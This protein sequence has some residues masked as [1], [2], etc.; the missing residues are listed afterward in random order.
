M[1][2]RTKLILSYILI[3]IVVIFF[4]LFFINIY[5]GKQFSEIIIKGMGEGYLVL[6]TPKGRLFLHAMKNALIWSGI[7]TIL[8]GTLLALFLS[9]I[10]SSPLKEMEN[11]AKRIS[12]GDYT[13]RI[14]VNQEDELGHLEKTL[15]KM[16]ENL[17]EIENMRKSLVQN[18]SHDLRT[19][20]TSLKGYIEI[21]TDPEFTK[22]E[23]Q[24]AIKVI[25]LEIERMESMLEELS[26]L[27]AIDSRRYELK[28][29][30]I[31]LKDAIN[32]AVELMEINAKSKNLAIE[33]FLEDSVYIIGDKKRI[34]EIMI[35]LLSNAI[36]FTEKGKITVRVKKE[37]NKG[38]VS[39]KDTGRGISKE[40]LPKI[41]DRFFRG[42]RS[43]SKIHTNEK[44]GL[45]VGLTIVK[46]LV[47][48]MN[49]DISVKS[50]EGKGTEFTV[51]FPLAK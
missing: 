31:N 43:R 38:V 5:I 50:E 46:E 18:V 26:K 32:E 2:F 13:A 51:Y 29:E 45:G 11:F 9:K 48:A 23:K 12:E 3:V 27:S 35:N 16:A 37:K 24:K 30:K 22:E 21:V 49:G 28:K 41:F 34:K 6:V 42:E 39:V 8:I 44:G 14:H 17:K 15:N 20:L 7:I 10:V 33:T 1:K 19:P 4:A 36:K 40:D 47:E 25:K